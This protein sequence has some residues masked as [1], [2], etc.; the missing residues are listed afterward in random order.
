MKPMKFRE[1]VYLDIECSFAGIYLYMCDKKGK[2]I[3]GGYV[4]YIYE[5]GGKLHLCENLIENMFIQT[6]NTKIKVSLS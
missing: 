3:S 6:E 2:L 5:C 4:L 1:N